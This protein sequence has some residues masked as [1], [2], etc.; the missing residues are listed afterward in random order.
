[1]VSKT[2]LNFVSFSCSMAKRDLLSIYVGDRDK[3]KDMLLKALRRICLTT[4]HW[5]SN[6]TYQHYI[7]IIAHFVGST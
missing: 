4:D 3:V 7:C 1:M 5:K 2:N 6:H